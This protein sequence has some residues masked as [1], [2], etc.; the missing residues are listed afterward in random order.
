M[1]M[2]K[3]GAESGVPLPVWVSAE[4]SELSV[5][6]S[7]HCYMEL[8]ENGPGGISARARAVIWSS[9]YRVIRTFFE[10][11]TG[12]TLAAGMKV[13]VRAQVTFSEIYSLTLVVTDIEPSFSVG[14]LELQRQ[15]VRARLEAEGLS[16]MNRSL[17][18]PVRPG[19]VAVISS[20]TAAGYGD[21]VRHLH[22]NPYGFAFRTVL[23]PAVMQGADAPASVIAALDEVAASPE[24]PDVVLILRGGGA[25]AD[26]ACYDDYDLAANVAQFPLPVLTGIGHER[27]SHICDEMAWRSFKTPTAAADFL[28]E[29]VCAEDLRLESLGGRVSVAVNAR[30]S[31]LVSGLDLLEQRLYSSDPRRIV[32]RGFVLAYGPDGRSFAS[33]GAVSSGDRIGL[34]AGDGVLE[35][36]VEKVVRGDPFGQD[37]EDMYEGN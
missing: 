1:G 12:R 13:L 23:F 27:D 14:A 35:C 17:D 29:T 22:G 5:R 18:M 15:K 25:K 2:V 24:M 26:L 21:F 37:K 20:E 3:E 8:V 30:F 6:S 11:E 28:I 7:G 16:G 4:I 33:V 34:M 32:S 36:V 19:L 9:S 10:A 31:A